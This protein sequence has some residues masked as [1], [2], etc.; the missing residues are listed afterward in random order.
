MQ[1][2]PAINWL[3]EEPLVHRSDRGDCQSDEFHPFH[4]LALYPVS[5][6][7][8]YFRKRLETSLPKWEMQGER[9]S[10]QSQ[11]RGRGLEF[12]SE[13]RLFD[14]SG[15]D[16]Y[17][18]TKRP[19][20]RPGVCRAKGV[21]DGYVFQQPASNASTNAVKSSVSTKPVPSKS[22]S[23]NPCSNAPTNVM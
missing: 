4:S 18:G 3:S 21:G 14:R 13:H 22:A 8:S 10:H 1:L 6:G 19:M 20:K 15:Y 5:M 9:E 11:T 17:T 7:C 12:A 2:D 16:L 23:G